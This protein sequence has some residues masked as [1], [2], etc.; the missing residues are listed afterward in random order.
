M[1]ELITETPGREVSASDLHFQ[2]AVVSDRLNNL[3]TAIQ[4]RASLLL[5]QAHNDYERRGLSII[6]QASSEAARF[7]DDLH[8]LSCS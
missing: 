6:L 1:S 3:L 7:S 8:R 5:K 4:I 2:C